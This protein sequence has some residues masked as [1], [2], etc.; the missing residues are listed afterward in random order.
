[1]THVTLVCEWLQRLLLQETDQ[2]RTVRKTHSITGSPSGNL[3]FYLFVKMDF[4][5]VRTPWLSRYN[6][7]LRRKWDRN[8]IETIR[9]LLSSN[10]DKVT[11]RKL[12]LFFIFFS[13]LKSTIFFVSIQNWRGPRRSIRPTQTLTEF[14]LSPTKQL[15]TSPEI[16]PTTD[17]VFAITYA[18]VEHTQEEVIPTLMRHWLDNF[19]EQDTI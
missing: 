7:C 13:Y 16:K 3:S 5:G 1:M 10:C 6:H 15:L 17:K 2:S 18:K 19:T 11:P 14:P 4:E 8:L 12:F 9:L